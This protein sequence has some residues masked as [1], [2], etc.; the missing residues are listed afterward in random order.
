MTFG[1]A[2]GYWISDEKELYYPD[3]WT[4]VN[5][6]GATYVYGAVRRYAADEAAQHG[7][8]MIFSYTAPPWNPSMATGYWTSKEALIEHLSGYN[9]AQ[10]K[11]HPGVFGHILTGEPNMNYDFD[12]RNPDQ[13]TLNLIEIMKAGVQYIKEQ[14]PTH[15]VWVAINP[16]GAYSE[17]DPNYL[18]RR[19]AWINLFIDWCDI[20]DFHWYRWEHGNKIFTEEI[21]VFKAKT[22]EMMDVLVQNSKGKPVMLGEC[23]CPTGTVTMWNGRIVTI[24]EEDQKLYYQLLGE[25]TKKRNIMAVPFK[26]LEIDPA[27]GTTE[28][29]GLFK[30]QNDG[31]TNIPKKAVPYLKDFL[32]MAPMPTPPIIQVLLPLAVGLTLV[33]T[34]TR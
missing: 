15:P 19:I 27:W 1:I 32:G 7:K 28:Q 10:Y 5:M 33:F 3:M 2:A 26:L 8:K 30:A 18:E 23:G 17:G 14:D 6:L 21:D 16:A 22:A 4:L 29:Y 24:S 34:G 12:P 9:I 31:Q 11:D 20:L 25:E 13:Y